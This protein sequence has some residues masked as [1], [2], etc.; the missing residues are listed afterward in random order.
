[1]TDRLAAGVITAAHGVHGELLVRCFSGNGA[2]LQ[3]L[4]Q[5]VLT[6]DGEERCLRVVS[7]RSRTR[8]LLLSVE[9]VDTREKARALIGS[10]IWVDRKDAAPLS[11]DEYYEADLCR[12]SLYLGERMVGA[13]RS[14]VEAGA[15]QLLEVKAPDGREILV[16][17]MGRFIK[18]VDLKGRR[19]EL[20]TD[21]IL[22]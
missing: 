4:R 13:V 16:P 8:D 10:V 20:R 2:H 5:A 12:C 9:S 1:M 14:V 18:E 22:L 3:A 6:K 15:G 19:I 11:E 7:A 21:E 17:F